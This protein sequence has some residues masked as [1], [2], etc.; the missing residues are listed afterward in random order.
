MLAK[1]LFVGLLGSSAAALAQ[2]SP[3]AAPPLLPPPS[4]AAE[5][6][7]PAVDRAPPR[8]LTFQQALAA[9]DRLPALTAHTSAATRWRDAVA[10]APL[11]RPAW[12]LAAAPGLDDTGPA[13]QAELTATFAPS[14][15]RPARAA[16]TAAAQAMAAEAQM[17][18]ASHRRLAARAWLAA[19]SAQ[20][21][22]ALADAEREQ[23]A[24]L[25]ALAHRARALTEGTAVEEAAAEAY[26]AELELAHLGLEG[27]QLEAALTLA[28]ATG[29]EASAALRAQG[30]LPQP[31]ASERAVA[32][33]LALAA[34]AAQ[35]AAEEA[36]RRATEAQSHARPQLLLGVRGEGNQQ[37]AAGFVVLGFTL[38]GQEPGGL[39]S[40]AARAEA[41][42]L[43]GLAQSLRHRAAVEQT[44]VDHEVEHAEATLRAE[45][46]RT[47]ALERQVAALEGAR[48]AG[49]VMLP[50]LL[51]ARR[52]L[53]AARAGKVRA[54]AEAVRARVDRSLLAGHE[55]SP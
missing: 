16:A 12:S 32:Q 54:Q 41:E 47:A 34:R 26:L 13:W 36:S 22:L 43:V 5:P 18:R 33:P 28:E 9:S 48:R 4:P 39:A 35:A 25:A 8:A 38:P 42:R 20:E 31:A 15:A 44:R 37:T 55:V 46:V 7:H 10:R 11:G 29:A 6:P 49:E 52:A 1:A 27:E 17:S 14:R 3:L 45:L 51:Q 2:P 24:A 30:D 23:A 21:R 50:E 40:V 19:W 53:L